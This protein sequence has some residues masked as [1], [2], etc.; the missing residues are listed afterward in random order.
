MRLLAPGLFAVTTTWVGLVAAASITPGLL[1][2]MRRTRVSRLISTDLP[3]STWSV[4]VSGEAG[5][6]PMPAAPAAAD[7]AQSVTTTP[8]ANA[9]NPGHWGALCELIRS[10][11]REFLFTAFIPLNDFDGVKIRR[12]RRLLGR[13]LPGTRHDGGGWEGRRFGPRRGHQICHAYGWGLDLFR[14]GAIAQDK[15]DVTLGTC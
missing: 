11:F 2:M 7:R 1:T 12:F 8:R 10:A 3:A 13:G 14:V 15:L 5:C 9:P 6:W 4:C